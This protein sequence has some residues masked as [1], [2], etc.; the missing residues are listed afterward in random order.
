MFAPVS[1]LF[2]LSSTAIASGTMKSAFFGDTHDSHPAA[3]GVYWPRF[4]RLS[5]A[6]S[7][8]KVLKVSYCNTSNT[9]QFSFALE[10]VCAVSSV[11]ADVCSHTSC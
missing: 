3:C 4:Y 10:M 9:A 11:S 6:V 1:E 7:Q 5:F 8:L 2:Y